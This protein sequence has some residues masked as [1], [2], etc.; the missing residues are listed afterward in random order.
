M[1]EL[2]LQ[3]H[4]PARPLPHPPTRAKKKDTTMSQ[5]TSLVNAE[6]VCAKVSVLV[7]TAVDAAR[8]AHA[9]T[10]RGSS[11]KPGGELGG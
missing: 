11:T 2:W 6:K 9:P 8:N 10:G 3:Q 1:R 7:A 4:P 5:I